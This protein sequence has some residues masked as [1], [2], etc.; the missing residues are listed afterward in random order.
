MTLAG[1]YG[2]WKYVSKLERLETR[3]YLEMF[4]IL[5]FRELVCSV[6]SSLS[7][8]ITVHG[9]E[10]SLFSLYFLVRL[11]GWLLLPVHAGEDRAACN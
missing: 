10:I 7:L 6:L 5:K 11:T 2:F 3:R 1:V 8:S 9:N 4:Y